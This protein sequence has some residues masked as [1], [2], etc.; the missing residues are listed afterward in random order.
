MLSNVVAGVVSQRLVPTIGGGRIA[1]VEILLA[2]PSVSNMIREKKEF[3]LN[4]VIRTSSGLGMVTLEKSL[5]DLVKAGKITIDTAHAYA[6]NR[7]KL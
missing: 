2:T 5:V 6:R 1:A 7:R 3:Q 4:N